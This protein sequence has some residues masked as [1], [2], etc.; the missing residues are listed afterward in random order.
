MGL[1]QHQRPNGEWTKCSATVRDCLYGEEN[2]SYLSPEETELMGELRLAKKYDMLTPTKSSK[3]EDLEKKNIEAREKYESEEIEMKDFLNSVSAYLEE[4]GQLPY[5][6]P[7]NQLNDIVKYGNTELKYQAIRHRNISP[8]T[9]TNV[10][11]NG[12]PAEKALVA[13][14]PSAPTEAL[15]YLIDYNDQPMLREIAMNPNPKLS[16]NVLFDL[17][18]YGNNK[19]KAVVASRPDLDQDTLEEL[20]HPGNS[21]EVLYSL[22]QNNKVPREVLVNLRSDCVRKIRRQQESVKMLAIVKAVEKNPAFVNDN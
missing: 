7:A 19:T 17:A 18:M 12:S 9:L 11:K 10:A 3:L 4:N 1:K 8:E 13:G 22:A 16:S 21:A 2:H 14:H 6:L 20:S 5:D 15:S